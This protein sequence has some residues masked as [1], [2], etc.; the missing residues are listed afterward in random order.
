MKKF[1][2]VFLSI[3]TLCLF[4]CIHSC[5]TSENHPTLEQG[6]ANPPASARPGVY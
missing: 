6:F 1:N 3:L 4:I 5:R 2:I